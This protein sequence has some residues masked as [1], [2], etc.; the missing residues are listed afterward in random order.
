MRRFLI[1][2]L[3]L[4]VL[5]LLATCSAASV[6]EQKSCSGSGCGSCGGGSC[7]CEELQQGACY[8]QVNGASGIGW[9]KSGRIVLRNFFLSANCTG[10][11]TDIDTPLDQCFPASGFPG[12]V[13]YDCAV[14]Y[15]AAAARKDAMLTFP[16]PKFVPHED[17]FEMSKHQPM[18]SVHQTLV[19][20]GEA[21]MLKLQLGEP[22]SH[23]AKPAWQLRVGRD[24][25]QTVGGHGIMLNAT[26]LLRAGTPVS[27]RHS[28]VDKGNLWILRK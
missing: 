27:L 21:T 28:D 14:A 7:S 26:D 6:F 22:T 13:E 17:S 20:D 23:R 18:T 2:G 15:A 12:Y 1:C 8:P 25:V 10:P 9:C 5:A 19:R 24:A 11:Y 4:V 16:G 3:A